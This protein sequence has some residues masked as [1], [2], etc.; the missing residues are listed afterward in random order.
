MAFE[1]TPRTENIDDLT[2]RV[3][4][5]L[6]VAEQKFKGKEDWPVHYAALIQEQ[7]GLTVPE[8]QLVTWLR[9]AAEAH[10]A[11]EQETGKPDEDW[12][13]WYAQFIVDRGRF[14]AGRGEI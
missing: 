11:Y 14:A 4:G 13:T 12:H 10:H 2:R 6:R 3:T 1:S 7:L 8:E 5:V 9:E